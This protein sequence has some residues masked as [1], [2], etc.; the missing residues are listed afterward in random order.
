MAVHTKDKTGHSFPSISRSSVRGRPVHAD[1]NTDTTC[2]KPGGGLRLGASG[3]T[4]V[5]SVEQLDI[6]VA[7][8]Y[9]VN[10]ADA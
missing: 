1:E 6:L 8:Y 5:C 2:E 7:H 4:G 3:R 10:F 9:L